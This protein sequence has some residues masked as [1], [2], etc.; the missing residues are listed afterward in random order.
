VESAT[1]YDQAVSGIRHAP[2]VIAVAG[3]VLVEA[4]GSTVGAIGV[5]GAPA[6]SQDEKCAQAGISAIQT[7]LEF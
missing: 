2:G 5:S 7:D 6:G 1:A 4:A 3:G